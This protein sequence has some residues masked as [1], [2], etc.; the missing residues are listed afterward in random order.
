MDE[1]W[2]ITL[3]KGMI[4]ILK[5]IKRGSISR[6]KE[7]IDKSIMSLEKEIQKIE[8]LKIETISLD[9]EVDYGIML[10]VAETIYSTKR[11]ASE[12]VGILRERISEGHAITN[13]DMIENYNS[14]G[15]IGSGNITEMNLQRIIENYIGCIR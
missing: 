10:K 11:E 1:D 5:K 8:N 12:A 15:G 2:R 9:A 13:S 3:Y 7:R 14:L 6:A 4:G